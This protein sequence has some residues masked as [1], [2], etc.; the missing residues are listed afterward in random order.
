MH[1]FKVIL[2]LALAAVPITAIPVD[3]NGIVSEGQYLEARTDTHVTCKP[4]HNPAN[5]SFKVSM[6]YARAQAKAAG[7]PPTGHHTGSGDPHRY[8]NGDKIE[9]G[10]KGCNKKNAELWEYPIYWEGMEEKGKTKEWKKD[11]S[12]NGQT[13]TPLR[14]VYIKDKGTHDERA[15]VCGVMTHSKI[16]TVGDGFRGENFFQKCK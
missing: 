8:G 11:H 13:K 15:K 2:A 10:V 6:N 7:F 5:K 12:S 14:V 4:K 16:V 1:F 3:E 9:W